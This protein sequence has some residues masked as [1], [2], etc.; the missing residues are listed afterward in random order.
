MSIPIT[1]V[2]DAVEAAL[3]S[4]GGRRD[5]A[6]IEIRLRSAAGDGG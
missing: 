6:S 1:R 3:K 4:S 2:A 5:P